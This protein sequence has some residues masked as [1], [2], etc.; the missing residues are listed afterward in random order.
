MVNKELKI[1]HL[2]CVYPP[3]QGGI[4]SV[5]QKYAQI[6]VNNGHEVSIYTP[7]YQKIGHIEEENDDVTI[8]RISPLFKL[9]NAGYINIKK[10]LKKIEIL[11]IHYPFYA[12]IIPAILTNK[13]KKIVLSWHMNPNATGIKGFIFKL[14]ELVFAPWIFKKADKIIVSTKDYF[15]DHFLFKKFE[16]KIEELPFSIDID[17]FKPC[18]K[19]SELFE[20]YELEN[21]KVL[22]FVGG[23]DK[24]HYFKGVDILLK[25][26]QKLSKEYLL[27][28]VGEG[29]LKE[30]Y[31]RQAEKLKINDRVIFTG[32]I[33][34][35]DLIKHYN[36]TDCLILPSINQGEAFGIVQ[37]EAMACAKPVIVSDLPGVRTVLSPQTGSRPAGKNNET[38]FT[39]ENRNIQD[40]AVKINKLFDD[41]EQY[42]KFCQNAR[43]RVLE[44]FS[45]KIISQKLINIYENLFNK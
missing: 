24:A 9:G 37:I 4:G 21:K 15:Q 28:I 41:S 33:K 45:D 32:G 22:M 34:N 3:Y 40:L 25:A 20:E 7:N 29:K 18:E 43:Q 13:K 38:G 30:D 31:K 26:F 12:S 2:T 11:H 17:K 39:F 36:L 44:N 35:K 42:E 5:T 16:D 6:A 27:I 1:A 8:H 10:H 19:D 14:Y 23:L